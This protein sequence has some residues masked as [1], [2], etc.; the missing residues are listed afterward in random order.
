M[1]ENKLILLL[2]RS[3]SLTPKSSESKFCKWK[4]YSTPSTESQSS[5]YYSRIIPSVKTS[6][7]GSF[8]G[9]GL[10]SLLQNNVKN[11]H[12]RSFRNFSTSTSAN[13]KG[14]EGLKLL[15]TAGS[16]AQEVVG[17]WL[18]VSAAWV[19]SMV[20]LGGVT[21]LAKS[22]LPMTDWKFTGRLP[23]SND[24][25][26]AEFEKYKQSHEYKRVNK[27]MTIDDFR[28]MYYMEYAHVLWGR[29]LAVMFGV[30][31]SYFLLKGYITLRLGLRLSGL[32]A[33]CAGQGLIGRWTAKCSEEPK[34]EFAG[35]R[36]SFYHLAAHSVSTF[37]V[38]S[39]LFWTAL[40][41]AMP[42]SPA[43]SIA[44]VQ[45]AAKVKRFVLPVSFIVGITAISGAFVAES[46]G[47]FSASSRTSE[48]WVSDDVFVLKTQ[49][50]HQVLAAAS[51]LA[52]GGLWWSTRTPDIPPAL[53]PL[54]GS[55]IGIA[56]V[57]VSLGTAPLLSTAPPSLSTLH[58]AGVL[59]LLTLAIYLNHIVRRPSPQLL[60]T[61]SS[62]SKTIT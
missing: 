59:T 44:W 38:Y 47:A 32:F 61:L 21:R 31:F 1:I 22:G 49:L 40:S 56:A 2:R 8:I 60:K 14:T 42:E 57:Q 11:F 7:T 19:Y 43:E 27:E 55:T 62:V 12:I 6:I 28:L 53:R 37:A 30:P 52:I 26:L 23:F 51:L 20:V 45:Q 15:V 35:P 17:I 25:W 39:G 5:F 34:S 33:L 13:A 46:G 9:C 4:A 41:V 18:F 29:S 54:I 3:K 50:V 16:N 10:R 36:V 58:Q 24:D 48:G